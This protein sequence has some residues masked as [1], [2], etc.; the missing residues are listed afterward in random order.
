MVDSVLGIYTRQ[1]AL[2]NCCPVIFID[3][4]H[5]FGKYKSVI[6]IAIALD[7]NNQLL[8]IAYTL[9]ESHYSL[10]I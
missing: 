4:T 5:L 1:G 2:T 8:P 9:A 7:T 10:T 6:I 3:A